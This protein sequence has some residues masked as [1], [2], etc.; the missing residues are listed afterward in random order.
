MS[1]AAKKSATASTTRAPAATNM[2]KTTSEP[3]IKKTDLAPNNLVSLHC[4]LRQMA[5]PSPQ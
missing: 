4:Y 5:P 2:L 1:T 3:K